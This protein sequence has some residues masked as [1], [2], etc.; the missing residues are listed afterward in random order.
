MLIRRTS[1]WNQLREKLC[2]LCEKNNDTKVKVIERKTTQRKMCNSRRSLGI[3]L[4]HTLS[5]QEILLVFALPCYIWSLSCLANCTSRLV[6]SQSWGCSL[7][8][9]RAE[10][11]WADVSTRHQCWVVPCQ[12]LHF[13]N[14]GQHTQPKPPLQIMCPFIVSYPPYEVVNR[15]LRFSHNMGFL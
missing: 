11:S 6:F 10:Y 8:A 1:H 14:P 7:L 4:S 15:N 9:K 13:L 12:F 5:S 2:F 3:I